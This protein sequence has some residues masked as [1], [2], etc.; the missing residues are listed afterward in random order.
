MAYLLINNTAALSSL[1]KENN[2][3]PMNTT[4][5]APFGARVASFFNGLRASRAKY[6]VFRS[7][8]RELEALS[9]RELNDL[10]INRASIRAIAYQAAYE[11]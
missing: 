10:G 6:A 2:M 4:A 8:M 5:S 3:T 7:T 11:G 1:C 9:E